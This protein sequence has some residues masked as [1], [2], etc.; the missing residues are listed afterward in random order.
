ML[1]KKSCRKRDERDRMKGHVMTETKA[2]ITKPQT[3][4]VADRGKGSF[5]LE[6]L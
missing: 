6:P 3:K 1:F 4:G 2:G 5:S